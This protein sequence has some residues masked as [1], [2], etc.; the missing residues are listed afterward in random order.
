MAKSKF[1]Y[2]RKFEEND[3]CLLNCWIVVRLDGRS[4]HRWGLRFCGFGPFLPRF[5]GVLGFA[6]F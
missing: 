5:F 6:V 2:V 4:F 3:S 1:E